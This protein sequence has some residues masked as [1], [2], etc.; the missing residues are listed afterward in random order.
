MHYL[1]CKTAV[2]I[3]LPVMLIACATAKAD[4]PWPEP[5]PLGSS[6]PTFS[7]PAQPPAT[8]N[9]QRTIEAPSETITIDDAL[10]RALMHNPELAASAWEV[11]SGEARTIQARL[12]PNPEIEF[13]MEEFGGSKEQEDSDTSSDSLKR[14]EGA[15][16]T[17]KISQL[18]E[19][20]GKRSKRTRAAT[21][22]H[23]ALGW[24]FEAKRLDLITEVS[25]S[26]LEVLALQKRLLL[27][28]KLVQ[29]SQDLFDTVT[30]RVRAGKVAP[31][32]ETNAQIALATV[33]IERQRITRDLETARKKLSA[34]W[35]STS[36]DFKQVTGDIETVSSP[37]PLDQLLNDVAHNPDVARW[38][39][40]VEQRKAALEVAK[41]DRIPDLTLGAGIKYLNESDDETYLM[42]LS[43]PIPFFNRN[44]GGVLEA[45]YA[46]SKTKEESAAA[47]V[48][49][50][51]EVHETY[52]NLLSAFDEVSTLRTIV[53]PGAHTSFNAAREGYREG[54][55]SYLI[56][57]DAQRTLIETEQEYVNAL[58]DYH[59]SKSA[60]ERLIAKEL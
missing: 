41:A 18:V 39:T 10:K 44:Q 30:E 48:R 31:V 46:V 42:A 24:D 9:Q 11:R 47:V 57:L 35:G 49:V 50:T 12:Y 60:L 21:L 19:L 54:K 38:E 25:T 43:L 20:G 4:Q 13:E 53:L 33:Q 45:S 16:T 34:T 37:P 52:Q 17:V 1:H 6:I 2:I 14:F 15:E 28:N 32:E 7:A 5:R 58:V 36:P 29:I 22:E 55:F 8:G 23:S 56:V 27:I 3:C 26:L 59:K 40:E 51:T